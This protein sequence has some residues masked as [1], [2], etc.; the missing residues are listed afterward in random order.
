MKQAMLCL[1]AAL[2][3]LG[4][5]AATQDDP[6]RVDTVVR[7]PVD[8]T[9]EPAAAP[10]EL[11]TLPPTEA[12]TEAPAEPAETEA[13]AA[14]KASSS[15]GSSGKTSSGKTETPKVTAPPPEP[16]AGL[17]E[18]SYDPSSYSIGSLE[19]GLMDAINANR[20]E[21]GAEELRVSGKL[22]GIAHLRA[23]EGTVVYDHTRPDGRDYST[24]LT[25]Y[26]YGYGTV[27]ELMIHTSDNGDAQAI[28]QR[29]FDSDAYRKILLSDTYHT[30]GVGVCNS[31]GSFYLVCLLVG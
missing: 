21:N 4:G 13:E 8:P 12:A 2:L 28:A 1:L 25:D 31:G 24:A 10:S 29:W 14:K 7:I 27:K 16:T 6:F 17:P 5:C 11:P 3:M 26:D 9:Q 22:S 30:V 19:S 20:A 15:K 23:R 18:Q